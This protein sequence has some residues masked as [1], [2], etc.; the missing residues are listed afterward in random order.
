MDIMPTH[1]QP[2]PLTEGHNRVEVLELREERNELFCP[3]QL[4]H[5]QIVYIPTNNLQS[6]Q[7]TVA[8]KILELATGSGLPLLYPGRTSQ[9]NFS[10]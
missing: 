6:Q 3:L 10:G 4:Q 8:L 9:A 2:H 7:R 1:N 5:T